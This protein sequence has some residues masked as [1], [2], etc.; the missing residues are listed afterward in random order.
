MERNFTD[1]STMTGRD[2]A[3]FLERFLADRRT[4]LERFASTICLPLTFDKDSLDP[5]WEAVRTRVS[6]RSGYEPPPL[7]KPGP[8]IVLEQ[9]ESPDELPT[10]F[11]HPSGAG[12]A[13]FSANTLWLLDGLGRYFG[14]V[15]VQTAGG[16]WVAGSSPTK[17]YVFQNQ[18]VIT[19]A[20]KIPVNPMQMCSV[21]ASREL[22][23]GNERG[24][25]TLEEAY[26]SLR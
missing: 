20:G 3:A 23:Q 13:R 26:E 16:K 19:G 21:L 15:L 18:P 9:L 7:G 8:R 25:R 10:W 17:G 11:H 1:F 6:W 12:Y 4:C 2:A 24:P 14:E 5:I 22:R